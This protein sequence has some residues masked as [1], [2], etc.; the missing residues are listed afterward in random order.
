MLFLEY[1]L[2]RVDAHLG[3]FI[4]SDTEVCYTILYS[5]TAIEAQ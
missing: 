1:S 3:I 4:I 5:Y 2:E